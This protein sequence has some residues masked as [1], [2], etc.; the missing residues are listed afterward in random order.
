MGNDL[1]RRPP[2]AK[3]VGLVAAGAAVVAAVSVV[4]FDGGPE[5]E[6]RPGDSASA[7]ATSI[8]AENPDVVEVSIETEVCADGLISTETGCAALSDFQSLGQALLSETA[9]PRQPLQL[10]HP[11]DTSAPPRTVDGCATY[12]E[13]KQAG[14]GGLSS[15]D[16]RREARFY[17]ACGLLR[18]TEGASPLP[19]A[20]ALDREVMMGLDRGTLPGAGEASFTSN[21]PITKEGERPAVWVVANEAF[22]CRMAY[23]ATADFNADGL[24]DH[25]MEWALAS[26]E[27]SYRQNG[28]GLIETTSGGRSTFVVIDPFAG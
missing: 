3:K 28:F 21:D 1:D 20:P 25:L 12:T 19:L 10:V 23:L 18:L 8:T 6:T 7:P 16:M 13:L 11:T 17:R 22:T 5:P 26:N 9:L 27:G 4:L 2:E 14:W 24:A 15:A